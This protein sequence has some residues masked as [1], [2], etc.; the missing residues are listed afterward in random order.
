MKKILL[1]I[2]CLLAVSFVLFTFSP[3]FAEV[4]KK[5]LKYLPKDE[6]IESVSKEYNPPI[7]KS[8]ISC[9]AATDEATN[10][11]YCV[12]TLKVKC[13]D[14]CLKFAPQRAVR[15]TPRDSD[16]YDCKDL[17]FS[18][19]TCSAVANC[20]CPSTVEECN[21][22]LYN[23]EDCPDT[24]GAMTCSN[25]PNCQQKG[26]PS[27]EPLASLGRK[28]ISKEGNWICEEDGLPPKFPGC[29]AGV[30]IPSCSISTYYTITPIT[31]CQGLSSPPPNDCYEY[32]PTTGYAD[33]IS[34]C[35]SYADEWEKC[36]KKVY[37]CNKNTCGTGFANN[38]ETDK[39]VERVEWPECDGYN[40]STCMAL[41]QQA[42]D[43][44]TNPSPGSACS[45][46]FEEID[47]GLSYPFVARSRE[48]FVIF[49]QVAAATEFTG[50]VNAAGIPTYFFTMVK[51]VDSRGH[52]VHR[53][54]IHQKSF[55]GSFS[56][57]SATS[58]DSSIVTQGETYTV[59]LYYFLPQSLQIPG[60][61]N[62]RLS[63][64]INRAELIVMRTRD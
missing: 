23:C 32:I 28:C 10:C 19:T 13:P 61:E 25:I 5:L 29:P 6:A 53:S 45:N 14:C 21:T 55:Q 56:I 17:A 60:F 18:S 20:K 15:C 24:T 4:P 27:T 48:T 3:I 31:A 30:S 39:C 8:G 22:I 38:C 50:A 49:W 26:C 43:C 51:V 54:I 12:N 9:Q 11:F 41:Q 62:L 64:K 2:L 33:C 34:N 36:T 7:I 58:L 42:T 37:C 59:R 1:L 16:M 44:L 35:S 47:A 46:C 40:L 57:F 63:A 52:E